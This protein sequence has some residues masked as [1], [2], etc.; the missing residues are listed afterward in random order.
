MARPSIIDPKTFSHL[1]KVMFHHERWSARRIVDITMPCMVVQLIDWLYAKALKAPGPCRSREGY[2]AV[3]TKIRLDAYVRGRHYQPWQFIPN[4]ATV[5]FKRVPFCNSQLDVAAW[6]PQLNMRDQDLIASF[7]AH[8]EVVLEND[9]YYKRQSR[10]NQ[11]EIAKDNGQ[12]RGRLYRRIKGI[13]GHDLRH[14]TTPE[15]IDRAMIG[16]DGKL[17]VHRADQAVFE[18]A[19]ASRISGSHIGKVLEI[20]GR[21]EQPLLSQPQPPQQKYP[22]IMAPPTGAKHLNHPCR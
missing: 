9:R 12:D 22:Q 2:R 10:H 3:D 16:P 14:A 7:T 18:A 13:H 17:V 4:G 5:V 19:V 8:Q 20:A 1:P 11:E 15:E 21:K 6:A